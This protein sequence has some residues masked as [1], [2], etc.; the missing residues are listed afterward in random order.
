MMDRNLLAGRYKKMEN[1]Y[2]AKFKKAIK[3]VFGIHFR[4]NI[5]GS[6]RTDAGVHAL[7]QSANFFIYGGINP[8]RKKKLLNRWNYLLEKKVYLYCL[9]KQGIKIL[10]LGIALK[11]EYTSIKL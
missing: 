11:R 1:Q 10:M 2:K 4:D 7:G 5:T 3:K 9:L 6:G 8:N